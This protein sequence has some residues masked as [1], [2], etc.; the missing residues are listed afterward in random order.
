MFQIMYQVPYLCIEFVIYWWKIFFR[1]VSYDFIYSI[2]SLLSDSPSPPSCS[3]EVLS[4]SEHAAR[5]QRSEIL[6]E[7]E[8]GK[9]CCYTLQ[10]VEKIMKKVRTFNTQTDDN[11]WI[12]SLEVGS[13][14]SEERGSLDCGVKEGGKKI[15]SVD[16]R[17]LLS[18]IWKK[19]NHNFLSL[20]VTKGMT[21]LDG[22]FFH[23]FSP[24]CPWPS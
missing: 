8:Q 12:L 13:S 23:H 15:Q 6:E 7:C 5:L 2:S 21:V 19:K 24:D 1:I 10:S 17:L 14:K 22:Y 20:A 11:I 18:K 9:N 4:S 3:T 16:V